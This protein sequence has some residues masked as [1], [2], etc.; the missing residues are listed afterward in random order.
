MAEERGGYPY[1]TAWLKELGYES[2]TRMAG[3]VAEY[4]GWYTCRNG[5]YQ[6]SQRRGFRR[7]KATRET[8]HPAAMAAEAW[9]DLLMNER[10]NVTSPDGAMQEV[11][12]AHFA[13]FGVAHADF[14]SRAFAL[15]TGALAADVGRVSDDGMMHPD[16]AIEIREY[17]A[18]QV[19]PIT[20]SDNGCT[21]AA[22]ATRVEVGGKDYDQCQAHVLVGGTYHILTQLFSVKTHERAYVES[23]TA[24]LDTRSPHPTFAL[25]RPAVPNVHFDY[26]AMGASVFDKAVSAIKATDEALT[27]LIANERVC[28]P[29]IFVSDLMIEKSTKRTAGGEAVTEYYAFGEADDMVFRTPPGDEGAD[30]MKVVQPDMMVSECADALNTG[31]NLLSL[32]CGLGEQYWSWD[33]SS[34]LKTA[35]EVVSENSML[36]RSL[37]KHQNALAKSVRA[38]VR[39]V[40]GICRGLCGTAVDPEA[41]VEL[42]FDDS[43]ITDEQADKAQALSEITILGVPALKR[44][45]LVRYCGF[46]EDEAAAAVPAAEVV[47][48]GF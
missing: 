39:G 41:E 9:S 14:V 16:A 31:L 29:R 20:W 13:N 21:Q 23:V 4:W 47:D 46:D 40:A 6:Y 28:R 48:Q 1:M 25:V 37:R 10:L 34:G 11:I 43:I 5:W 45:Y 42:D 44:R 38:L 35:T 22:F 36:A 30:P 33:K 17:D 18:T 15:G 26:C 32:D 27:T 19:I 24:D 3:K 7:F 12:D 2:D 8:M